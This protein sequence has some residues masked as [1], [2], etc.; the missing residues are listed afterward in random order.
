MTRQVSALA[1]A[2]LVAA[3]AGSGA[4]AELPV[5]SLSASPARI[6]LDGS[7]RTTIT[8]RNFGASSQSVVTSVGGLVVDVRGR[9]ALRASMGGNRSAARWLA[10]RPRELVVRPGG[11]A[12]VDV[13]ARVPARAAPGDHHAVVVFTTR[14][15]RGGAVAIRM[16]VAVRVSVRAAGPVIRSLVVRSVSVRRAAAVRL[17]DVWLANRGNVTETLPRGRLV[18]R[19]LVRGR[20]VGRL[21]AARR[22]VLPDARAL[23]SLR[24]SGTVRGRVVAQVNGAGARPRSFWIRL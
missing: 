14:A 19:L 21:R 18:V 8:L 6:A 20:E 1:A 22:E 5:A 10:V 12:T 4:S 11:A 9:P 7:G 15:R 2:A 24:Y 3:A 23:V 16:R 13:A 17:V